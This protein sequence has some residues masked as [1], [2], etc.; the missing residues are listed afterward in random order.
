MTFTLIIY[1]STCRFFVKCNNVLLHTYNTYVILLHVFMDVYNV[2][3]PN[4]CVT[5]TVSTNG[6][7]PLL[8]TETRV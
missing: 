1:M 6:R 3:Q 2:T 5:E 8:T 4:R 7:Q